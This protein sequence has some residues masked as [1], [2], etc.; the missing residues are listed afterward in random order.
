MA[1]VK[2][3]GAALA[4]HNR[5]LAEQRRAEPPTARRHSVSTTALV[6]RDEQIASLRE[7]LR[8]V[9][10]GMDGKAAKV[11][12]MA[13]SAGASFAFGVMERQASASGR[14]MATVL[15]LPP[16]LAWAAGLFIASGFIGGRTGELAEAASQGLLDVYA[17]QLG[18]GNAGLSTSSAT[19]T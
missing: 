9:R 14:Q 18:Q 15:D 6:K 13:V 8:R 5:R 16:K 12:H 19:G 4:A 2:L 17:Y 3:F 1:E 11:Q 7:R 10:S